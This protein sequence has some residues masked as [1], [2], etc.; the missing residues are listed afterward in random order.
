MHELNGDRR[1]LARCHQCIV[2]AHPRLSCLQ[3]DLAFRASR[4][5]RVE[6][7]LRVVE[8]LGQALKREQTHRLLVQLIHRAATIL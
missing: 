8:G 5:R 2:P 1:Q 7:N 3:V 4:R 6:G